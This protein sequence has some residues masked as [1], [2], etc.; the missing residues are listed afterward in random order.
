MVQTQLQNCNFLGMK[1]LFNLTL[2]LKHTN[3][4]L[5]SMCVRACVCECVC[6]L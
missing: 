5:Y 6:V 4:S 2:G 3:F 1:V